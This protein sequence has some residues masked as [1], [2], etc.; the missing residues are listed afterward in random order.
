MKFDPENI[1]ASAT[2][3]LNEEDDRLW[4]VAE[5]ARF[6][7]LSPGS[8]YHLVSQHRVPVIRFSSRCVRFSRWALEAWIATMTVPADSTESV[9]IGRGRPDGNNRLGKRNR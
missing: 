3:E 1:R 8:L 4:T 9:R 2:K 7:K 5:A 6:L